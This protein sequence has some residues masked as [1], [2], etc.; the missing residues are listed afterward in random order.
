MSNK[1]RFYL[2]LDLS[3][4]EQKSLVEYIKN[5]KSQEVVRRLMLSGF[6]LSGKSIPNN[7]YSDKKPTLTA[8]VIWCTQ[9]DLCD[10]L[11]QEFHQ[12]ASAIKGRPRMQM[13]VSLLLLGHQFERGRINPPQSITTNQ[14]PDNREMNHVNNTTI[15]NGQ[16]TENLAKSKALLRGLMG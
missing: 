2:D 1:K 6:V 14:P 15:S 13:L 9:I 5:G 3:D 8:R 12:A 4:D 7:T 10:Q 11:T 16:S